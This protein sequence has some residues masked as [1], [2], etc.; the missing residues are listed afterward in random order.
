MFDSWFIYT[1]HCVQLCV[2]VLHDK[3]DK[4]H[5]HEHNIVLAYCCCLLQ[6][7]MDT[8][9]WGENKIYFADELF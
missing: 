8:V 7:C 3:Y 2:F 6:S 4:L 1:V 9:C 5:H